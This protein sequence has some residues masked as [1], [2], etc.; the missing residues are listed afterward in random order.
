MQAMIA[1]VLEQEK[2]ITQVLRADKKMRH[3]VPTWQ[4]IEVLESINKAL[5]PLKDFTDA[6]SA[7]RYPTVSY[8]KPL[9]NKFR[10]QILA[11]QPGETEL[12]KRIKQGMSI[13]VFVL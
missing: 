6:L 13:V 5:S 3:C 1:R 11:A 10:E 12:T 7:E 9:L 2:A 8:L 4:D